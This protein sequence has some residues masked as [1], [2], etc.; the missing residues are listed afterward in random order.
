MSF[1]KCLRQDIFG[2]LSKD[3]CQQVYPSLKV[4]A[5]C[6]QGSLWSKPGDLSLNPT[7]HRKVEGRTTLHS[8]PLT[9]R[10]VSTPPPPT[11]HSNKFK[12]KNVKATPQQ[13]KLTKLF[14]FFVLGIE[15]K[16]LHTLSPRSISSNALASSRYFSSSLHPCPQA[17]LKLGAHT[18][19]LKR[20]H[21]G[22][23]LRLPF[24]LEQCKLK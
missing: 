21:F 22:S 13:A 4:K 8:W 18:E 6:Q 23:L 16:A 17:T 19:G 10:Q 2:G 5:G 9:S 11:H 14:S 12:K 20:N 3:N 1:L 15:P 24:F 7:T